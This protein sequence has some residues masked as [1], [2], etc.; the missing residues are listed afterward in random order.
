MTRERGLGTPSPR[1]LVALV[2][3]LVVLLVLYLGRGALGPF[4]V[5]A[6]L[7]YI[8]DPAVGWLTRRGTPRW[9][10]ILVVY[11]VAI[12]V[13]VE[14]LS[15][16]FG[17]L[18]RQLVDFVDDL[19][20]LL[21]QVQGRL[22][23][24][25]A[26]YDQVQLPRIL[27]DIVDDMLAALATAGPGGVIDPSAILPIAQGVVAF[28]ASLLGLAIV[29]VWAFYLLKDRDRLL[30]AL[31]E[32][33][34]LEWRPDAWSLLGIVE[35]VFR[36]WLRGQLL[37]CLAVGVAT[38]AGLLLLSATVDPIFGRFAVL[39]AVIAGILELLPI[40]GPI[41]SMVPTVLLAATTG[42]LELIV[43]VVLLYLVVQQ[44][45]NNL[46]VPKIQGDAIELHPAV[47]I[48]A[49]AVG[50][51]IAGFLGAIFAL[52]IAAAARD[53]YRYVFQRAGGAPPSEARGYREPPSARIPAP[54]AEPPASVP[55]AL[56]P[57]SPSAEA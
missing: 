2:A 51:A 21:Q 38:F 5:G 32:S 6:L 39:L 11:A 13:L 34:P 55:I 31:E 53:V 43:A 19:P 3:A 44:L 7:V 50:A 22:N 33:L 41:I 56:P 18:V 37:L 57:P 25:A 1:A 45:E 16:L 42:R 40:I 54:S 47:V 29:P 10:A 20:R 23:A 14:G 8:L 26:L 36:R 49:L 12:V 46:L 4:I 30:R 28:L 17:P 48:L 24:L 52:P 27:R 35:R 9:L 15:L